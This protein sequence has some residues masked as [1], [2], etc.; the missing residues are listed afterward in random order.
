[1]LGSGDILYQLVYIDDLVDGIILCG[2]HEKAIGEV[3]VL[4]GERPQ[5]LNAM[6]ATVAQVVGVNPPW[7]KPPVFPVYFAGFLCE[8]LCKPLGINPPLYRRRV[9]FFIKNRS[10]F[11]G[12][13]KRVLGYQPKVSPQQGLQLT[14]EW[15]EK[16]GLL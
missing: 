10:C 13:S 1:M 5:T 14:A 3:F 4:T 7:L 8:L 15:Y 6:V 12:K 11:I 2:T 16:E 9:D